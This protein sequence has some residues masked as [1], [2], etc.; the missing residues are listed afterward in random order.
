MAATATI[1][2][3]DGNYIV[4]TQISQDPQSGRY[5]VDLNITTFAASD[6]LDV[7]VNGQAVWE[8]LAS[9]ATGG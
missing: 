5:V 7:R 8:G 4:N 6:T 9:E 3:A 2:S 1:T